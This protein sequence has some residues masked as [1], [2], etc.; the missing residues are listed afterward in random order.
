MYGENKE[1]RKQLPIKIGERKTKRKKK[2]GRNGHV[3]NRRKKKETGS[4]IAELVTGKYQEKETSTETKDK[5]NRK[6]LDKKIW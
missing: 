2:E 6:D 3:K 5:N 4:A 1:K